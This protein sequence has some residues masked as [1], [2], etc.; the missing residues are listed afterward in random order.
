ML[1]IIIIA[2]LLIWFIYAFKYIKKNGAYAT[3][4]SECPMK[5]RCSRS[6]EKNRHSDHCK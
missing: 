3:V 2:A 1:E 6:L 5:E 4:C